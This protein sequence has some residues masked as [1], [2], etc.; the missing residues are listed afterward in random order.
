VPQPSLPI[1]KQA[2]P[3]KRV[4][5]DNGCRSVQSLRRNRNRDRNRDRSLLWLAHAPHAP[6]KIR[7][8]ILS[9]IPGF[10]CPNPIPAPFE[11]ESEPELASPWTFSDT[12]SPSAPSR[13]PGK[14]PRRTTKHD[15]PHPASCPEG[16]S[17]SYTFSPR[18]EPRPIPTPPVPAATKPHAHH[19]S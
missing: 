12:R 17:P 11:T 9:A 15:I 2:R 10:S 3:K 8:R 6:L 14:P 16:H 13:S 7:C 1:L 19:G 4:P 18:T 5:P